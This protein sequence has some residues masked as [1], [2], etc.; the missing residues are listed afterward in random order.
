MPERKRPNFGEIP[1]GA[2]RSWPYASSTDTVLS[3]AI[4]NVSWP[5]K[6][7]STLAEK[8]SS[9]SPR[10]KL[11]RPGPISPSGEKPGMRKL[12]GSC[13]RCA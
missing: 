9:D 3:G 13:E 11:R 1:Y 7:G 6:C 12:L 2:V 4:E 5:A 8:V 10:L